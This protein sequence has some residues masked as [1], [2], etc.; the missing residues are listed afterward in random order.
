MHRLLIGAVLALSASAQ[1]DYFPLQVGNQWVYR[2]GGRFDAGA[3][4]IEITST[5]TVN[6][7]EYFVTTGLTSDALLLRKNEAGSLVFYNQNDG[8]EHN[9]VAFSAPV[10]EAFRT[11]IDPCNSVAV[12]RSK[13]ATLQTPVGE[14]NNALEV[15]YSPGRCADAGL[16]R[17]SFLPNIGLAERRE[18]NFAGEQVW[19]LIYARVGDTT[20]E[21]E[22]SFGVA[23]DSSS[24]KP[25]GVIT[26]RITLRN[27]QGQPLTLN[28]PSSQDFDVTIKNEAGGGVYQWSASRSFLA[29]FR[30]VEIRGEK[31][32]ALT[33][34]TPA[35][36]RY[37]A[38][39]R[40][41]V[42]GRPF[43]TTIPFD[44]Q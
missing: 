2:V 19:E 5:Q 34:P 8:Q 27:T 14:F 6:L 37:M 30:T 12:I 44:V 25:G 29:V 22:V 26:V 28:F 15:G 41:A 10:G 36:G 17:E 43:E 16:N 33:V 31:N 39:V 13:S 38:T 9:W 21:K 42:Q 35:P 20:L 32:W 18:S 4:V 1:P 23:L 11:E 7:R 24:Y 3:R 40:L